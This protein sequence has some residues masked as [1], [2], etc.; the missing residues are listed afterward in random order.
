MLNPQIVVQKNVPWVKERLGDSPDE[1]AFVR[2]LFARQ[3]RRAGYT[4]ILV[5][6]F[7]WLHPAT[8]PPAIGSVRALGRIL[9]RLPLVQEFAG[10]L[11][12]RA[13]TPSLTSVPR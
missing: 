4:E 1:T 9:E 3:L 7:D 13:R 12:I 11:Y 8:P 5:R 10:S 6:P 2:W